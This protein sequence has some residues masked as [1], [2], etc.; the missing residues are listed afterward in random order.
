MREPAM[1]ELTRQRARQLLP[2]CV[3]L[4]THLT[5]CFAFITKD[6]FVEAMG[7]K[8]KI[9]CVNTFALFIGPKA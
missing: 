6:A 4:T 3:K 8:A 5:L 9:A 2:G 1:Q 7:A